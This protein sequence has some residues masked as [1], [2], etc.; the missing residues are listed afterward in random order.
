MV[1]GARIQALPIAVRRQRPEEAPVPHRAQAHPGRPLSA[2]GPRT[3]GAQPVCGTCKENTTPIA[4]PKGQD[5][6]MSW[7]PGAA[8]K[9]WRYLVS[10]TCPR[11]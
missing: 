10:G 4:S 7:Q 2:Q 8:A 5:T 1:Q 11:P 3:H 6:V 9:P